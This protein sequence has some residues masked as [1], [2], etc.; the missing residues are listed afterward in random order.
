MNKL[1]FRVTYIAFVAVFTFVLYL[2]I[3][4]HPIVDFFIAATISAV[5][6]FSP[7][8]TQA[9]VVWNLSH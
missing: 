7:S 8:P 3:P 9:I 1:W 5:L 6:I 2:G 4:E